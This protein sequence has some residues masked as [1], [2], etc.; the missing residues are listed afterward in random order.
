MMNSYMYG[1]YLVW[2][3]AD[4]N[5]VFIDGRA[6]IYVREGVFEDYLNIS[7]LQYPAPFLLN[8]YGIQSVLLG[9]DETLVTYLDASPDWQKVYNDPVSVLYVRRPRPAGESTVT[10]H[11]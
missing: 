1:G 9:H 6:D 10:T 2:Q 4:V 5:K 7:R 8:A 11:K 3:M